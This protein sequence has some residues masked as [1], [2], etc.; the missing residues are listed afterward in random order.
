[1]DNVDDPHKLPSNFSLHSGNNPYLPQINQNYDERSGRLKSRGSQ[2]TINLQ[3]QKTSLNN[4]FNSNTI[5]QGNTNRMKKIKFYNELNKLQHG[6]ISNQLETSNNNYIN[7][8][9]NN[10]KVN[11]GTTKNFINKINFSNCKHLTFT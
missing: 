8:N 10:G 4:A 9:N 7:N 6:N 1:M 3:I 2:G 11:F 5:T